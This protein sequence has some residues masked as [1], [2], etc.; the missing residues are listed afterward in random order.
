MYNLLDFKK[1]CARLRNINLFFDHSE[2]N[3][4]TVLGCVAYEGNNTIKHLFK[5]VKTSVEDDL[6]DYNNYNRALDSLQ[7]AIERLYVWLKSENFPVVNVT[8]INQNEYIFKWLQNRNYG[9][10]YADNFDKI[11]EAIA[12]VV[13]CTDFE[14]KIVKGKENKAKAILKNVLP[15]VKSSA[16]KLNFSDIKSRMTEVN[17]TA[18]GGGSNPTS[19]IKSITEYRL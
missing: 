16:N 10:N 15:E 2:K 12:T 18:V 5:D 14:F 11:Y 7:F 3:G 4:G 9:F 19:K 6:Q 1:G 17:K 8:L 13:D